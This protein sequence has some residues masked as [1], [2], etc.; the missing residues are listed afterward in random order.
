MV[1]FNTFICIKIIIQYELF[2][3]ISHFT[4]VRKI[5]LRS[6]TR[7]KY[8][9]YVVTMEYKNTPIILKTLVQNKK[10]PYFFKNENIDKNIYIVQRAYTTTNA[11]YII[12]VWNTERYN[13]GEID[14]YI[15]IDMPYNKYLYNGNNNITKVEVNGGDDDFKVLLYKKDGIV[16]VVALLK[17]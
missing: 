13:I 2:Q 16:N 12:D 5:R 14:K 10:Y 11:L 6:F 8:L 3:I 15:D 1:D 9:L 4:F 7:L 17:F